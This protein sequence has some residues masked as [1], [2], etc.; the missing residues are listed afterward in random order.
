MKSI[1]APIKQNRD[2]FDGIM[3]FCP[4]ILPKR[5]SRRNERELI[6]KIKIC[7]IISRMKVEIQTKKYIYG[8]NNKV[9]ELE[10]KPNSQP[11]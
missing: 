2:A 10:E 7:K 6:G 5:W 11:S 3:H 1:K 9:E 8:T 4:N